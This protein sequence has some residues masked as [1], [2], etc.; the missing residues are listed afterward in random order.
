MYNS[1][2]QR[3]LDSSVLSEEERAE[4]IS[5]GNNEE[6]KALRFSAPMDFGTAGLRS[7]MYMGIGSMN[8]YTVAQ[9][10]RGIAALIKGVGGE[11]RGVA[12]AFDSRNNSDL[13]ARVSAC[14]LAGA[15][16]RSY[17]FND[18]RPTPELSF[19]LRELNC[20]AGINITASHNPKIP[21]RTDSLLRS[22]GQ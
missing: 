22:Q 18:I 19:A 14:V 10:T 13:F 11:E 2:Y 1:E 21:L 20:V 5:I 15:G 7:T 12:I 4:L 6:A 17:I 16:I 3:W 8:R 9:T